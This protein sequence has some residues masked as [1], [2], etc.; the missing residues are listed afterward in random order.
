MSKSIKVNYNNYIPDEQDVNKS[1]ATRE[2]LTIALLFLLSGC[3]SSFNI[4]DSLWLE[5]AWFETTQPEG[6]T[7]PSWWLLIQSIGTLIVVGLL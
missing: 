6:Y 5:L 3:P 2:G 4:G 7:L 1:A